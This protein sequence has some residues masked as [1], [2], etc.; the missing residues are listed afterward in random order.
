MWGNGSSYAPYT[1]AGYDDGDCCEDSCVDSE[2][3]CADNEV[4][5]CVDPEYS[6]EKY[7]WHLCNPETTGDGYCNGQNN[8][9]QCGT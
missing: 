6:G 1:R 9:L 5:Y 2:Y 4:F 8:K 3:T 7:P